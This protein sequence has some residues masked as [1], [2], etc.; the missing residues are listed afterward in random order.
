LRFDAQ[1]SLPARR[2]RRSSRGSTPD[3]AT[4]TGPARPPGEDR[5]A[6]AGTPTA[7]SA[8]R[9]GRPAR[10][11]FIELAN[12]L[13]PD[14]VPHPTELHPDGRNHEL[15]ETLYRAATGPGSSLEGGCVAVRGVRHTPDGR[16]ASRGFHLSYPKVLYQLFFP[17]RQALERLADP[18]TARFVIESPPTRTFPRRWTGRRR[19]AW[20]ACFT[21]RAKARCCQ[22]L[23]STRGM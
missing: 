5:R 18:D 2:P 15:L 7:R 10:V 4:A 14:M 21:A 3:R 17:V 11:Q 23:L 1:D 20:R 6:Q 12:A 8:A 16:D 19:R 22:N 13:P 9:G